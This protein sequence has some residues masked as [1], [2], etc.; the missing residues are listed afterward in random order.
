[1]TESTQQRLKESEEY[2]NKTKVFLERKLTEYNLKI[3]KFKRR[4]KIIKALFVT[5]IVISVACSTASATVCTFVIPPFVIP[6]LSSTSALFAIFS[7]KFN[8]EGKKE[9]I[10]KAIEVLDR[11]KSKIDYVVSCNGNFAEVEYKNVLR[12]MAVLFSNTTA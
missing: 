9:E 1:M 10:T 2:K 11:V 8:L 4:R 5:F 3:K 12:E 6:I 7:V